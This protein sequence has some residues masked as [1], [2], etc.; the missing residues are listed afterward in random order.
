MHSLVVSL[1]PTPP[2]KPRFFFFLISFCP[3]VESVFLSPFN[4][5]CVFQV[6]AF[7][8][9]QSDGRL[10]QHIF[11]SRKLKS[12]KAWGLY[13]GFIN[14]KLPS[15]VIWLSHFTFLGYR[16]FCSIFRSRLL[17]WS[18]FQERVFKSAAY[19]AVLI[20]GKQVEEEHYTQQ[21]VVPFSLTFSI[22]PS[23]VS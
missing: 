17:W 18:D 21:H 9:C 23:V 3:S 5:V 6:S 22:G 15:K 4:L 12:W 10:F 8:R 16:E 19:G 20:T 7:I 13:V 14:Q 1:P 11:T 2:E